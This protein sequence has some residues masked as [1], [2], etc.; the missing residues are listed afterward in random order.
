LLR[1]TNL[2]FA[3]TLVAIVETFYALLAVFTP[4]DLVTPLTGWVLS[5]DGQWITKL[6]GVALASQA[7]V[8]W[9]LRRTPH[10]GVAWALAFYQFASATVDWVMWLLLADEGIF[11]TPTAR[12]GILIAVP[13]HYL[14]GL[15]LVIA[16]RRT[17]QQEAQ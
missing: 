9:T 17:V 6:L 3:F 4:P 1:L 12:I 5:A 15:L 7:W 14:L 11:S 2:S 10:L 13:S 16:I 8:A